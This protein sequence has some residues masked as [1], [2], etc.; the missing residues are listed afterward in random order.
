M[1]DVVGLGYVLNVLKT[2]ERRTM[3]IMELLM[4]IMLIL[5]CMVLVPTMQLE[6]LEPW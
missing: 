2:S 4:C 3:T 1:M 6:Q 5:D